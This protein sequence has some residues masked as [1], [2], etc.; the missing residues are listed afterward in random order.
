MLGTRECQPYLTSH[1]SLYSISFFLFFYATWFLFIHFL[2]LSC[3]ILDVLGDNRASLIH[4][5]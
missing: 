5:G 3:M 2:W 4:V 1:F